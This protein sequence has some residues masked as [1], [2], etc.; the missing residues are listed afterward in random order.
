MPSSRQ[1]GAI[2]HPSAESRITKRHLCFRSLHVGSSPS[3]VKMQTRKNADEVDLGPI[4]LSLCRLLYPALC[5]A[6]AYDLCTSP[7][8]DASHLPAKSYGVEDLSTYSGVLLFSQTLDVG[9]SL[10]CDPCAK[11]QLSC[12]LLCYWLFVPLIDRQKKKKMHSE[13]RSLSLCQR[14]LTASPSSYTDYQSGCI[15]PLMDG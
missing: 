10:S 9:A 11:M 13:R 4:H 8:G 12:E 15:P 2:C 5:R 3:D 6:A 7:V 14:R 1:D